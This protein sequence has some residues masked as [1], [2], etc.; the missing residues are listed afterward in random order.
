MN[1]SNHKTQILW[2]SGLISFHLLELLILVAKLKSRVHSDSF[3]GEGNKPSEK[4][5]ST[6]DGKYYVK[7][8]RKRKYCVETVPKYLGKKPV[9]V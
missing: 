9:F 2:R 3:L 4:E 5:N 6:E 1:Q 8:E 7:R